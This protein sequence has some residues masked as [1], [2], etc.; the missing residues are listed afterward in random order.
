M[1]LKVKVRNGNKVVDKEIT[2]EQLSTI[3][4]GRI[5]SVTLCVNHDGHELQAY[6]SENEDVAGI[7]IDGKSGDNLFYLANVE[8]PGEYYEDSFVARLFA[9]NCNYETDSSIALVK[10]KADGKK[11]DGTPYAINGPLTKIVYIDRD[12]AVAREWN[13]QTENL[14]EHMED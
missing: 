12:C 2:E 10:S 5:Q 9:G 7:C 1:K 8:T 13:E 14:S 3:V 11:P 4:G 6:A